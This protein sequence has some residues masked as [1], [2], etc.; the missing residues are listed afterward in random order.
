M[1]MSDFGVFQEIIQNI[2]E[3]SHAFWG[4]LGTSRIGGTLIENENFNL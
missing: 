4:I 1:N 2:C 3:G